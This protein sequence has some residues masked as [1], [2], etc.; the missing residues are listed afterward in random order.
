MMSPVALFTRADSVYLE[1]G[2]ECFDIERDARTFKGR[3]PVVAHPPCR[4]WGRL[5]HMAKP[6]HDERDLAIFAACTVRMNGGVLE[7][8]A[9]SKLF[10]LL[11]VAPGKRDRVGGWVLPVLQSWWGHPAPKR[12]WLYIVGVEPCDIPRMPLVLGLPAGR[13][14]NQ[15][16]ADRE[17][18]P[19]ELA[20]WLVDLAGR[21]AL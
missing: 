13:V 18:T 7:H 4:S 9:D 21:V 20:E 1:L 5:A 16:K 8:P 17:R 11:G 15:S 19:R 3:A 2:V 6:R 12:T 10:P 14:E